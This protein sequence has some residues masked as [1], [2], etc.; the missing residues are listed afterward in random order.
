MNQISTLLGFTNYRVDLF[1]IPLEKKNKA[2][3]EQVEDKGQKVKIPGVRLRG[4]EDRQ[5]AAYHRLQ[6][7]WWIFLPFST[8]ISKYLLPTTLIY[9]QISVNIQ[10]K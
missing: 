9:L 10:K 4:L 8:A 1:S 6:L 2:K 5:R 3:Q 7:T